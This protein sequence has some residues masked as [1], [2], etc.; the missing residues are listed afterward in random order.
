[1]KTYKIDVLIPVQNTLI[2]GIPISPGGPPSSFKPFFRIPNDEVSECE[3]RKIY[4]GKAKNNL[5]ATGYGFPENFQ[6]MQLTYL[7]NSENWQSTVD[8]SKIFIENIVDHLSFQI[9]E[10]LTIVSVDMID[11]SPSYSLGE[12][13]EYIMITDPKSIY[14]PYKFSNVN[15]LNFSN[16]VPSLANYTPITDRKWKVI[17]WWYLKSLSSNNLVDRIS[18][19]FIVLDNIS[20]PHKIGAYKSPCGHLIEDC[21]ECRSKTN[22]VLIGESIKEFLL[23]RGLNE[24]EYRE[25][26][27][28]RQIVHGKDIF[29][30]HEMFSHSAVI[31]K[32][33]GLVYDE[34]RN[35]IGHS[36]IPI[37]APSFSISPSMVPSGVRE[38]NQYDVRIYNLINN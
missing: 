18:S 31:N 12:N 19:I 14:Q 4:L 22:R 25:L 30:H 13:R 32:L 2:P 26:W 1:M 5:E 20:K 38:I 6:L 21:P 37:K 29:S 34:I 15:Q 9:Q 10:S 3:G 8:E 17:I 23:N 11:M 28:L 27:A 24:H 33:I 7:W 16:Y 35:K 36:S